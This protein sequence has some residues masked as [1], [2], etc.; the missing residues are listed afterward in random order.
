M[1][2]ISRKLFEPN[3]Y[4]KL[5]SLI[6]IHKL[7]EHSDHG[8]RNAIMECINSLQKEQDPK[9]GQLYFSFET[10]EEMGKAATNVQELEA[11]EFTKGYASYVFD[12][13][14]LRGDKTPLIQKPDENADRILQLVELGESLEN[15]C[16][17]STGQSL[18]PGGKMSSNFKITHECLDRIKDDRTWAIKQLQKLS[19]VSSS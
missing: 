5:K 1:S 4:T 14:A 2:K 19:E 10:I 11:V 7:I 8:A 9:T 17:S 13:V 15:K 6:I 16:K 3:I 18:A 12:F